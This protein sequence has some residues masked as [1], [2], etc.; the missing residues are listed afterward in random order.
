VAAPRAPTIL[1]VEDDDRLREATRQSLERDGFDVSPAADGSAGLLA[2]RERCPDMALLDVMLPRLDGVALC[3]AIRSCSEIPIVLL[4]ARSDSIDVVLGLE[5]GADDYVC[6]PFDLPVLS[7]RLRAV[8]R[9]VERLRD[10]PT[11]RVM[12]LEIDESAMTVR[13]GGELV[14]LTT[15]EFRLLA[16]LARNAGVVRTRPQLLEDVWEYSWSGDTRLV[17]VHVQRL[18][19][20]LGSSAIET[21][22]GVGYKLARQ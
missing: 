1:F 3:R 6:K 11:L 18:R 19:A 21:I 13:S 4:S 7:A 20:K 5:A 9:R 17:D 12:D 8:L 2:F 16:D 14:R 22:R 15:T 10:V